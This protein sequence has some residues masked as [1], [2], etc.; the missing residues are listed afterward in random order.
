V[1]DAA[2]RQ[3]PDLPPGDAEP[4]A[5][6]E[7]GYLSGWDG[8]VL[9]VPDRPLADQHVG[10]LTAARVDA[11]GAQVPDVAVGGVHVLAAVL[12]H[13]VRRDDV[14]GLLFRDPR[15]RAAVQG[16]LVRA[17]PVGR[18]QLHRAGGAG[19]E[20]GQ[21]LLGGRQVLELRLGAAE[22]DQL[23]RGT[24]EIDEVERHQPGQPLSA[25]RLDHEMGHRAGGGVDDHGQH[26]TSVPVATYSVASYD[27][28]YHPAASSDPGPDATYPA[29]GRV[30]Q[31]AAD[32]EILPGGA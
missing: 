32:R 23:R 15:D 7:P 16:R 30:P 14:D 5:V 11:Q 2:P 6:V 4:D 18:K 24:G 8:D 20:L 21:G 12:L 22:P 29:I 9:A 31:P 10:H 13:L 19:H 17:A 1:V 3:V 27:E 25:R 26:L 28:R